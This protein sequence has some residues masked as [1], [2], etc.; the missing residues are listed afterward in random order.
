MTTATTTAGVSIEEFPT[1]LLIDGQWVSS[2]DGETIDNVNP[3]TEEI[4]ASVQSA[5]VQDVDR[6]VRAARRA[7]EGSWR[8][9][10]GRDRGKLLNRLAALVER[11]APYFHAIKGLENGAPAGGPDVPMTIDVLEYFAG[12]ADK[13]HGRVIPTAGAMDPSAAEGARPEPLPS[14]VFTVREPIGVI[15]AICAWNAPLLTA[16]IK[17]G[18][19]LAAGN[20]VVFKTSE[21][22]MQ[23][24]LYLG[25]AG[26]GSRLPGW[27]R[28]HPQRAWHPDGRGARGPSRRRPHLVHGQP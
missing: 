5:S 18:P 15:G 13:I 16:A 23:A 10:S 21:E 25:Q 17:L 1:D 28:Q 14:H 12:W 27:R 3:A 8:A 4:L 7:F 20:T 2:S 22:S 19:M 11:D 24:V 26:R 9:T 6:A